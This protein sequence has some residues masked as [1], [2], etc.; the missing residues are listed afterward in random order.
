[1]AVKPSE[2][3]ALIP[4]LLMTAVITSGR[5]ALRM[6]EVGRGRIALTTERV[7]CDYYQWLDGTVS[8]INAYHGEFM[9]QYSWAEFVNASMQGN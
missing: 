6:S 8:G 1:M 4:I 7:D 2:V 3:L 9:S 5:S